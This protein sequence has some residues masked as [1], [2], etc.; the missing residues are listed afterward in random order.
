MFG[1]LSTIV[2]TSAE[3]YI[4]TGIR[5]ITLARSVRWFGWGM[6]ETLIPVL[7]FA[8]SNS[9]VEAGLFRAVYDIVFLLALPFVSFYADRV[10]AKFLLLTALAFG[11]WG[12]SNIA[13]SRHRVSGAWCR[14]K[15]R[16]PG[17]LI[18]L[19]F[20]LNKGF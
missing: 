4:P 8:F 16:A 6:C 10:P 7:L 17:R 15:L 14:R 19:E 12:L 11:F 5:V 13:R 18:S 20:V 9:Y 2:A 3:S 1:I